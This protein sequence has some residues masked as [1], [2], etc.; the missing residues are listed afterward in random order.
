MCVDLID[1]NDSNVLLGEESW[2]PS[3]GDSVKVPKTG[4]RIGV[5]VALK[6]GVYFKYVLKGVLDMV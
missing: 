2:H 1:C 3:I 5:V 4:Q 6:S